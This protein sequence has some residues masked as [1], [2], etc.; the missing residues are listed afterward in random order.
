MD[1]TTRQILYQ[2]QLGRR[3]RAEYESGEDTEE[4]WT[5]LIHKMR[6]RNEYRRKYKILTKEIKSMF[7]GTNCNVDPDSSFNE[8]PEDYSSIHTDE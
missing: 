5:D 2:F 8:D 7:K 4:Y 3:S 6:K 1:E